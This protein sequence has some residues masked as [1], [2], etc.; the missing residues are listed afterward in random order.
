MDSSVVM[1]P[2]RYEIRSKL[3]AGGMGE[4]YKAWDTQ[5]GRFAALKL[6]PI[7]SA[8]NEDR[9]R[10][11]AQEGRVISALNHPN[12]VTIY[13]VGQV[14]STHYIATE[15]V[16]GE[17]LRQCLVRGRVDIRQAVSIA[18]QVAE[19]L[20]AAHA[21]G[22]VHR[23]I[24]PENIMVRPD[25][26]VKV[27]DFGL[28]KLLQDG[29]LSPVGPEVSTA[30]D[31]NTELGTILGTL[32]YMSPEQLRG[33]QVDGRTDVWSLGVVLYE[34]LA[35]HLPFDRSTKS[36]LI[37]SILERQP[38]P[39]S[40][41]EPEVATPFQRIVIKALRKDKEQRY[42][43]A[44]EL[45]TELTLLRRELDFNTSPIRAAV[46]TESAA[47]ATLE[48]IELP[49]Y[50]ST[51][52]AV[53]I[54][55][56]SSTSD[57][58]QQASMVR[59]HA[60]VALALLVALGVALTGLLLLR[61]GF[62]ARSHPKDAPQEM[63]FTKL[64]T[65]R[66]VTA[67]TLSPDGKYVAL[68]AEDAGQ[69]SILVRQVGTSRDIQVVAPSESHY[70]G[71]TYSP[72]G[73]YVYYLLQEGSTHTLFRVPAFG[74]SPRKLVVNVDSPVT[75]S[76]DGRQ[77]AF[78]Q[79]R[80]E[81]AALIVAQED[82]AEEYEVAIGTN[83]N[84][85]HI[86]GDLNNGPAWSPDGKIIACPMVAEG[87]PF[88][89]DVAAVQVGDGTVG[90]IN[91]QPWHLV[92]QVAW[93]PDG[94]G[95]IMNAEKSPPP[96]SSLQLWL[97]PYP[98]GEAHRLTDDSNFYRT[99]SLTED[100]SALLTTQTDQVSSLWLTSIDEA[101]H[102]HQLVASQNKGTGG[103]AWRPDGSMVYASNETGNQNIWSMDAEGGNA[104]QL[105]FDEHQNVEP[106]ES[107]DGR[108]V[109]F[110][111]Y[112][113]GNAHVW[114][115]NPDGTGQSQLTFGQYEDWPQ[116][117]PDS[118]WI[119][120]HSEESSRDSIWKMPIEGGTAVRL[121]DG[122]AKQ[123]VISPDGKLL[124]CFAKDEQLD[125]P[126][127]LTVIPFDGRTPVKMFDIPPTVHQQW[128][129]PRWTTDGKALDYVVTSGGVSNI[130]RQPLSGGQ[131]RKVT[132]FREGQIDAFAWSPAGRNHLAC[133]RTS[134]MTDLFLVR[135]FK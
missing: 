57:A 53:V 61:N 40:L 25:G 68:L 78:L 35:G 22:V 23:D 127:R 122:P 63:Q 123:P 102:A 89:M 36:D 107:P 52:R 7:A 73:N 91:S 92:G 6:F 108:Y 99:V 62:I 13:D 39:L 45:L 32:T 120:Y 80:G 134:T 9:L 48:N 95:L 75:F 51:G 12:I 126:W 110:V 81:A 2:G 90:L 47:E 106:V 5:L 3:G 74:G 121:A 96:S 67:A 38:P 87:E 104:K 72:D 133:V 85:F 16:N 112:R 88:H 135:N 54:S 15:F 58:E 31:I 82:G 115:M 19:A 130:W 94:S 21:V 84:G 69:Q 116:V 66:K 77:I 111:S 114:R 41:P 42:Q 64:V 30:T 128:H 59:R 100:G 117:S 55:T 119:V 113:N 8:T 93:L 17:T 10:R 70:G 20:V 76:P 86:I 28:A 14:G 49:G 34:M 101:Q 97:L 24:K 83:G 29:V 18:R 50:E 26:Y 4:V 124:A 71:L 27:L 43:T 79:K 103:I 60:P 109:V 118:R 46:T 125:S 11:F 44:Q 98:S 1:S 33:Q 131:P 132:D 129:G 65:T 37:A 56:A 105:T